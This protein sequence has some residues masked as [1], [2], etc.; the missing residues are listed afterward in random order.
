[1]KTISV[2]T[3]SVVVLMVMLF[4]SPLAVHAEGDMDDMGDMADKAKKVEKKTK[5]DAKEKVK[6]TTAKAPKMFW[7]YSKVELTLEQKQKIKDIRTETNRKI[8]ELQD[9]E[10]TQ[11][12]AFLSSDQKVEVE[13][14]EAAKHEEHMKKLKAWTEK[15]KKAETDMK[16]QVKDKASEGDGAWGSDDSKAKKKMKEKKPAE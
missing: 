3:L 6:K 1:M 10:R 15:R 13:K 7:P 12:M 16:K 2:S 11:I 5:V 8:R 4:V 9:A 14:L